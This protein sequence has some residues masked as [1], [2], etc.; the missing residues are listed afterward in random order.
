M[1]K[2][3][4][5]APVALF[6]YKRPTHTAKVLD[7]LINC[8][9]SEEVNLFVFCD[10]LRDESNETEA[11]SIFAVR[12]LIGKEKRFKSIQIIQRSS[13]FG[14]AKSIISG[15]SQV[16]EEYNE[17]I[18]LEDDIIPS[19]GFLNYM[20][21]ALFLYKGN[22]KVG[23]IHAWNYDLNVDVTG[24]GTFF[25]P[26]AD[27]WGWGTWRGS[28]SQFE[29]DGVKLQTA[30]KKK[31]LTDLFGRKGTHDFGK[32][33][34]DQIDG[35]NDSWAI[36]WH[37][38][39]VI[40]EKYCLHPSIAIVKNIGLDGSGVHCGDT[41]SI[42]MKTVDY[43]EVKEI[44]VVESKWFYH[45][46]HRLVQND[47]VK[48]STRSVLGKVKRIAAKGVRTILAIGNDGKVVKEEES[49]GWY[50]SYSSF[51]EASEACG[52]YDSQNILEECKSAILKVKRGEVV[53][54]RDS[55]CFD[56]IQYSWGL[57]A[58]LQ[59]AAIENKGV[60][61]VIDFGGSLGSSYF[62]N[63][64]FLKPIQLKSWNVVEQEHFVACGNEYIKDETLSFW[65]SFQDLLC[66]TKC[67]VLLAS[68]VIQYMDD[69]FH[70]I[71][72]IIELDLPFIIVDRMAFISG[73]DRITVQKVPSSI[74]AASYPCWF[75][76]KQKMITMFESKYELLA[77]IDN[78]LI[79][80]SYRLEDGNIA[81]WEG[82]IFRR[83]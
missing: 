45:A 82:M 39:L 20:N 27:C 12:E 50:G 67:N 64:E 81:H 68:G 58:G 9:G 6:V 48:Q 11:K 40:A 37:A 54:E 75:F 23:C 32:M 4:T 34:Q 16:L 83:I 26:G 19:V 25:L 18:V 74:Y 63:K 42:K 51:L 59:R 5:I 24:Q 22:A 3:T 17:I 70:W 31:G 10:G 14:L 72:K 49:L 71:E 80:G 65:N 61:N 55:V 66:N 15:V 35:L 44:D 47:E 36:R 46:Y 56:K 76:N 60:L 28:W 7:A 38:S 43:I 1:T 21:D 2:T 41:D 69:P 13:N 79:D 8:D 73:D 53:Y 62:Q 77:E 57:L 29:E 52:G 33:L 78:S 30:I